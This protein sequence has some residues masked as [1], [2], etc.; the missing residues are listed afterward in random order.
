MG[1]PE[2]RTV[3]FRLFELITPINE[4]LGDVDRDIDPRNVF[5]MPELWEL[6]RLASVNE[7]IVGE[8]GRDLPS[9]VR[10]GSTVMRS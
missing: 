7:G 5:T 3:E 1:G 8:V 2:P 4:F 6:V 10:G 9:D